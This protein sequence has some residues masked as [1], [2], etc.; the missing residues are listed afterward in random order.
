VPAHPNGNG[1]AS[2]FAGAQP[3]DI[4][5]AADKKREP[6]AKFVAPERKTGVPSARPTAEAATKPEKTAKKVAKK[7]PGRP[8]KA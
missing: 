3:L 8:R 7:A 6:K 5:A 2:R 4:I 1:S